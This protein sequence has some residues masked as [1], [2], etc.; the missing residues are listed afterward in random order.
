[1][2]GHPSL[3]GHPSKQQSSLELTRC[4]IFFSQALLSKAHVRCTSSLP[5]VIS[6]KLLTRAHN[7]LYEFG[8]FKVSMADTG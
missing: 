3:S 6:N 8:S 1:M 2:A 5:P 7:R 4:G